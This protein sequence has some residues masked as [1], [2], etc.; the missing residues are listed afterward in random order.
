MDTSNDEGEDRAERKKQKR[1]EKLK[2]KKAERKAGLVKAKD[3]IDA[4][5]ADKGFFDDL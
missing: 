1:K 5:Q 2:Q 4:D 3:Q